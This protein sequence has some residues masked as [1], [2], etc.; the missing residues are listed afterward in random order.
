MFET[1]CYLSWSNSW[2]KKQ[3]HQTSRLDATLFSHT[4]FT[5]QSVSFCILVSRT[6]SSSAACLTFHCSPR[7]CAWCAVCTVWQ[8][9]VANLDIWSQLLCSSVFG[10][11]R[12]KTG[13][14]C[15]FVKTNWG[16]F[17][18][19]FVWDPPRLQL[20]VRICAF[21]CL[22]LSRA[23]YWWEAEWP[24]VCGTSMQ[25]VPFPLLTVGYSQGANRESVIVVKKSLFS[26]SWSDSNLIVIIPH[27]IQW[28]LASSVCTSTSREMIRRSD[29][30]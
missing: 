29:F 3:S 15:G 19:T 16:R 26:K 6:C 5:H 4:V 25:L 17:S 18:A 14:N 28:S 2:R 13:M 22:M 23:A 30:F 20:F 7:P 27:C 12:W 10:T 9:A 24:R 1:V 21:L 8:L 11:K